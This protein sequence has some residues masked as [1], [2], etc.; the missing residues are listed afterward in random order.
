[1]FFCDNGP[2]GQDRIAL[3]QQF[4]QRAMSDACEYFTRSVT[5]EMDLQ[6]Q[7]QGEREKNLE[8]QIKEL[9]SDFSGQREHLE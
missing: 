2:P 6:K 5:N 1:M 8:V 3:M 4:T 7:L 9:K